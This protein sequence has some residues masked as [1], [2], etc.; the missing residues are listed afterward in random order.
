MTITSVSIQENVEQCR[1]TVVVD[2]P[3]GTLNVFVIID[4][5]AYI[6]VLT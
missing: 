1:V 4:G 5:K 6:A 2:S 3:V